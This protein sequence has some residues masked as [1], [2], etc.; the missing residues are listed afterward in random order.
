VDYRPYVSWGIVADNA[1]SRANYFASWGLWQH[2]TYFD[3][4]V[5]VGGAWKTI[6][7]VYVLI[8]GVWKEIINIKSL[9][10]GSWKEI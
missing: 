9:V 2:Y 8:S 3:I 7:N 4:K 1:R 10:G 5:L 6:R